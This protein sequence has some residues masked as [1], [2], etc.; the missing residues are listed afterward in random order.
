MVHWGRRGAIPEHSEG[1]DD[2]SLLLYTP[3]RSV[4]VDEVFFLER[5]EMIDEGS[6]GVDED[7]Y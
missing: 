6:L 1:I 5:S 4:G 7:S 2:G 3:E